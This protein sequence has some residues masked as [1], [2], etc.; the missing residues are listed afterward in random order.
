MLQ[1]MEMAQ[2]FEASCV[3]LHVGSVMPIGPTRRLLSL[4]KEGKIFGK[5][6][7]QEK[8]SLVNERTKRLPACMTRA[9]AALT[10][11]VKRA[12][13]LGLKI[14]IENRQDYEDF[15]N[16]DEILAL[17]EKFNSPALGYWHDFGHAQIHENLGFINC[18]QWLDAVAPHTIG[19][20][21]HNTI[22]PNRDHQ[23]PFTGETDIL[24]TLAKLPA[25]IPL[26]FEMSPTAD[27]DDIIDS[28]ERITAAGYKA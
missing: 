28:F 1:T 13:E 18:N 6:Y 9:E 2:R 11:L 5:E 26:V 14:G 25:D 24:R 10:P 22:W 12:E 17:L 15:P 8:L 4:I 19:C 21:I 27:K 20:H 7:A 3:V 23:S 16:D